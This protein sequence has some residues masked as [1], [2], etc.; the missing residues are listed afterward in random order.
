MG[1]NSGANEDGKFSITYQPFV[2]IIPHYSLSGRSV[3]SL[4][5]EEKHGLKVHVG[6]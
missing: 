2:G 6:P 5:L 4:V 1:E 3:L